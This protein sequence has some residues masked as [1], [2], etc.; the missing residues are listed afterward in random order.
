MIEIPL[1]QSPMQGYQTKRD[2]RGSPIRRQNRQSRRKRENTFPRLPF[3]STEQTINVDFHEDFPP[4][5]K[6]VKPTQSPTLKK[7]AQASVPMKD[8]L[9]L[10]EPAVNVLS[11][12]SVVISRPSSPNIAPGAATPMHTSHTNMEMDG[13]ISSHRSSVQGTP[14]FPRAPPPSSCE[15]STAG[16]TAPSTPTATQARPRITAQTL[17]DRLLH[18]NA[19]LA[20][21]QEGCPL[22]M[23]RSAPA[24]PF[25]GPTIVFGDIGKRWPG[26][27]EEEVMESLDTTLGTAIVVEEKTAE[28]WTSAS[29]VGA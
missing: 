12:S 25:L 9:P 24:S 4:L 18:A 14:A 17:H 6:S 21:L 26:D 23:A 19:T 15:L 8:T 1:R 27:G 5:P 10:P 20:T 11:E 22:A 16:N 28:Q 3:S 29:L 7:I 13:D 2:H